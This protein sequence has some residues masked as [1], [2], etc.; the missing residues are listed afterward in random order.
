MTTH[1]HKKKKLFSWNMD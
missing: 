1:K